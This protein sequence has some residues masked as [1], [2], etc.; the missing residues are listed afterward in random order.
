VSPPFP[1]GYRFPVLERSQ[2]DDSVCSLIGGY[3]VR[4]PDLP[5]LAGQYVYGDFCNSALRAATLAPGGATGDDATGLSMGNVTS[6][7]EDACAR[8]YVMSFGGEVARLSNGTGSCTAP[9][10]PFPDVPKVSIADAARP[11]GDAGSAPASFTVALSKPAASEVTVEY[12]TSDGTAAQPADYTARSGEVTFAPGESSK[13]V[14]VP[15]AGDTLDEGDETFSVDLGAPTG[16]VVEDGHAVG[17][18]ADDDDAPASTTAPPTAPGAAGRPP[19]GGG[20]APLR[21]FLSAPRS[22]RMRDLFCA[23]KRCRGVRLRARYGG[24][25]TAT[26]RFKVTGVR[27]GRRAVTLPSRRVDV[28]GAATRSLVLR[29]G[30]RGRA[31][32]LRRSVRRLR[33]PVLTA[34]LV[35]TGRDG[36]RAQAV[37][38]TRL[39]R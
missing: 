22:A 12:A 11:E 38:S 35:F 33:R 7:G 13:T 3:V 19:E 17:T 34:T 36:R 16:A 1:A 9:V 21:L 29:F 32:R 25:G 28:G 5:E 20:A 6:F 10:P 30:R 8:I 37:A 14:G 39:R 31:A 15:V 27:R 23:R 18:I 4:D 26:W 2:S 24:A